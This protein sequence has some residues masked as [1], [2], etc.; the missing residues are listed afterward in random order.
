M[1]RELMLLRHG[2]SDWNSTAN[3]FNRPLKDRGKR[4]AQRMG[5]YLHKNDLLPDYVISSPAERA[6]N[7][8][9]KTIKSM[10]R[11]ADQVHTDDR[12]YA[13]GLIALLKV[14]ADCPKSAKRVLL[15]GHNPG[16]ED[17]LIHLAGKDMPMP[18]DGKLMPTA[19]LAHLK[20][21]DNWKKL[22][23]GSAQLL[24]ITRPA[25][26][27]KKF[28]YP[29]PNGKQSRERPGYYYTQS[30]VIPYRVSDGEPE[31]LIVSS[32]G[33]KHWVVPKGIHDPGLSAQESAAKEAWEE[34]GVE[35]KVHNKP[36]GCYQYEKWGATCTV[37]VYPM[38][39]SKM[40][41]E[42]QWEERHRGRKWVSA[43]Q[44]SKLLKQDALRAM[45]LSLASQ[46]LEK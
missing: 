46:L 43:A 23:R 30:A 22:K 5:V 20:L 26:L 13:A 41:P 36:I 6:R 19:T 25:T 28:P 2:K 14:L 15:V 44:A 4:S 7:T 33:K 8:A 29:S 11:R 40:L 32:S 10:G 37:E 45:V 18:D 21:P 12:I 38:Q 31:I 27:P 35:G 39:I 16:M 42:S 34:A 3:D 9:E 1:S 24:S 17:L